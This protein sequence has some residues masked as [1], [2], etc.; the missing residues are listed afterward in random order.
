MRP[1]GSELW[2]NTGMNNFK[3]VIHTAEEGGYWAEVAGL[4]GCVSVGDTLEEV[5]ANILDAFGGCLTAMLR[6]RLKQNATV[7]PENTMEYALA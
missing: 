4:P 1:Q 2:Y 5:K 3:I 6:W 7:T